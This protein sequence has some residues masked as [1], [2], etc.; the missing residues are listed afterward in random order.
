MTDCH[1]DVPPA[2]SGSKMIPELLVEDIS[3]SLPF[4]CFALGFAATYRGPNDNVVRLERPDGARLTL[5]QREGNWET[6]PMER[7]F[8]R[9]VMLQLY[10]ED[11]APIL[12]ALAKRAW[13]LVEGPRIVRRDDLGGAMLS[14]EV[15]VQDPN[16]YL[17]LITQLL[18]DHVAERPVVWPDQA[19][20]D[21][22]TVQA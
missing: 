1:E 21:D 5:T 15:Y 17:I 12:K 14:H 9:G 22:R 8:G 10:V 2:D 6:G 18:G 7:P 4:W 19:V 3:T 11:L 16:G 13:P 20:G